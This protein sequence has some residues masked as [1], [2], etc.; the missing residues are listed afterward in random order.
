[1]KGDGVQE[2][3]VPKLRQDLLGIRLL[4]HL[5]SSKGY[6]RW[7][8]FKHLPDGLCL[9]YPQYILVYF[10]ERYFLFNCEINAGKYYVTVPSARLA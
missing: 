7:R 2:T 9:P 8:G 10:H 5:E 3:P 1:L 4:L 6:G